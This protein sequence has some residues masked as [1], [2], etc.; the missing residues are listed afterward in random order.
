M[1]SPSKESRGSNR[2]SHLYLLDWNVR[3]GSSF[4]DPFASGRIAVGSTKGGSLTTV[5]DHERMPDGIVAMM[6]DDSKS[7]RIYWSQVGDPERNDGLMLSA[8]LDG[9]ERQILYVYGQIHTPKQIAVDPVNCKLYIS[10]REGMRVHRCN[11]DGSQK[12]VLI[13]AGD[14][15]DAVQVANHRL[16]CVGIA[17]D[18]IHGLFY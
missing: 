5:I 2:R 12:E 16:H 15:R 9:S 3:T 6:S 7:G 17:V 10:D 11:L 8:N 1:A 4:E 14:W 13:R 18:P